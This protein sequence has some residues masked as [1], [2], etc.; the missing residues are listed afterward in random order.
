MGV[1]IP[2]RVC[3]GNFFVYSCVGY[4]F[5]FGV[6]VDIWSV[7]IVWRDTI[8]GVVFVKRIDDSFMELDIEHNDDRT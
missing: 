5:K 4:L 6:G 8:K 3:N 2:F 1:V 7:D